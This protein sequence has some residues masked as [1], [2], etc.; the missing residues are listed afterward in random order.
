LI[1][2]NVTQTIEPGPAPLPHEQILQ[3][4]IK[5]HAHKLIP[6]PCAIAGG[7]GYGDIQRPT[8]YPVS[9]TPLN[10]TEVPEAN[11]IQ[12]HDNE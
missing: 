1:F 9:T 6:P 3:C 10:V 11:G 5:S 2:D 7:P 4:A 8:L 12:Q